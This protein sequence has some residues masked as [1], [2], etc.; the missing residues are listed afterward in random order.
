[1]RCL[2][3]R[4]SHHGVVGLT[5]SRPWK[6]AK[7]ASLDEGGRCVSKGSWA[8]GYFVRVPRRINCPNQQSLRVNGQGMAGARRHASSRRAA[9]AASMAAAL[10][11]ATVAIA[12]T[13]ASARCAPGQHCEGMEATAK[14]QGLLGAT[15][16]SA[17]DTCQRH[18][19]LMSEIKTVSSLPKRTP[20][21]RDEVTCRPPHLVHRLPPS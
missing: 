9:P 8:E 6:R 4:T 3:V 18:D 16:V 2:A 5:V 12:A 14:S 7:V 20:P 10:V 17:A 1:M 19:T 15:A 21:R 11:L 13:G